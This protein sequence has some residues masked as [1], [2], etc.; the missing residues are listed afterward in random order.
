ML[1]AAFYDH[2]KNL[3]SNLY[4]DYETFHKDTFSP[5]T[6]ILTTID[7]TIHGKTYRQRQESLREL[8]IDFQ[9]NEQAGLSCNE[10]FEIQNWFETNG[11][12]YGLLQ[13]FHENAIC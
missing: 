11:K 13:E 12:R 1:Y 9:Y 4:Y 3:H 10:L 2:D 6:E 7:F 8:A 5:T